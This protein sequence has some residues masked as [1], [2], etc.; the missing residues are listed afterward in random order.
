MI[1]REDIRQLAQLQCPS[2]EGCALSFYFQPQTPKNKSHREE[3]I[4]AKDLFRNA[5]RDAQKHGGNGEA[6]ADLERIYEVALH[7]NQARAKAIFACRAKN[8]WLEFDLPPMLSGSQ[9]VVNQRF[10]LTPLAALLGAQPRLSVVLVDRQ[11]A[12]LFELRL[13]QLIEREAMFRALPRRRSDGYA[14]YDA[15]HAQRRVE[16]EAMHHFKAVAERLKEELEKGA[17]EKL[18]VG[19]HETT[20]H[21]FESQLHPY[22]KQRLLGHFTADVATITN[23]GIRDSANRILREAQDDRRRT[24]VKELL[25]L[26]QRKGPSVTGLRRVLHSLELGEVQTLLLGENFRASAVECSSCGHIDAH[27]VSTCPVCSHTTRKLEDVCDAMI[28]L[29][30][31]QDIELFYVKDAPEFDRVGN[32]GALLRFRAAQG[33]PSP[34]AVAS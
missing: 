23:E 15:G 3:A 9:L 16:G 17:F 25:G 5:L 34:R 24:M 8:V 4:L 20:W 11:R 30:I 14:G 32:I 33:K 13:D 10:H 6:R 28:P 2:E 18:I 27:T 7:G 21:E 1:T 31:R 19:C 12:R 26:G 22:L 29:A